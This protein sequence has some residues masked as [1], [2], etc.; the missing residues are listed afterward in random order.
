MTVYSYLRVSSLLQD[1][2]NQRQGVELKANSLNLSIE[3]YYIDKVSGIT[4]INHRNLGKLLKRIKSGDV[5]IIAEISRLGRKLL[6][7]MEIIKQILEKGVSL[8]SVK[9][10]FELKDDIQ[11]KCL[12]FSFGISAEIER[13]LI[14][15]RT[16][17]A[18]AYRKAIGIKL[19]RPLGSKTKNSR[20]LSLREK[21]IKHY[22]RYGNKSKTARKYKVSLKTVRKIIKENNF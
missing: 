15:Q 17:E 22:Y 21:I 3:K 20:I 18:L 13:N 1:E 5:I 7:I 4:E 14:S 16:K 6:M 19:G 10:N 9:E 11:S 8:Y 12:I 2:Q